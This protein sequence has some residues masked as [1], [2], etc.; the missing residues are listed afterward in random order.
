MR[1]QDFMVDFK[2]DTKRAYKGDIREYFKED[3]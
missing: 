2:M 3:F 1:G